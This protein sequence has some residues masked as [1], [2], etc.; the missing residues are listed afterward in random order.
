MVRFG[1]MKPLLTF[2]NNRR[3]GQ[4]HKL[5][6]GSRGIRGTGAQRS[7]RGEQG[8]RDQGDDDMEIEIGERRA[9]DRGEVGRDTGIREKSTGT[10]GSGRGEQENWYQ[11]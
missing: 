9:Q 5:G 1:D 10:Q 3:G 2:L 8:H 7:G 11:G 4:K 6:E